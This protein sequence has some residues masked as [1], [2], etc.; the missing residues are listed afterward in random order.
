VPSGIR[1]LASGLPRIAV[2]KVVLRERQDGHDGISGV[3]EAGCRWAP[4]APEVT[5]GPIS[6]T[7]ACAL[8]ARIAGKQA[9]RVLAGESVKSSV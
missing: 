3:L 2:Q 8:V 6:T 5:P 9:L 7:D 4:L 1:P